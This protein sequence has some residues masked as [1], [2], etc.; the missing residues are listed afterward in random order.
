MIKY[1][2][3]FLISIVV[4]LP[5]AYLFLSMESLILA[6]NVVELSSSF[7]MYAI[8]VC[9]VSITET[10]V[11]GIPSYVV[12]KKYK[13]TTY[14]RILCLGFLLAL[15]VFALYSLALVTGS[16]WSSGENY[17]GT[18]RDMVINGSR[19]FWGWVKWFEYALQYGIHGA[20]GALAFHISLHTFSKRP[21]A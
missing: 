3:S 6:G 1:I 19:T 14:F 15:S 10:G 18:Y 20:V 12:F 5:L 11:L 17:Y 7:E 4:H 9:I 2:S 16:G 21:E 8:A 13:E